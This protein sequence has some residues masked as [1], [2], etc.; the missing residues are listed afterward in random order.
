MTF[1]SILVKRGYFCI[2]QSFKFNLK[3]RNINQ[4][5]IPILTEGRV[6][7]VVAALFV[8]TVEMVNKWGPLLAGDVSATYVLWISQTMCIYVLLNTASSYISWR[9]I[10]P[11]W[12]HVTA[13]PQVQ[14]PRRHKE[15]SRSYTP[16]IKL[17]LMKFT[18]C[19]AGNCET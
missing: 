11:P 2:A 18:T 15:L 1:G 5:N 3:F 8:A 7:T 14:T 4:K 19:T 17:L 16:V 12:H 13:L 10:L 9:D 6:C